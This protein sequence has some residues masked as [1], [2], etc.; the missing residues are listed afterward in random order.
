[1]LWEEYK[2]GIGPGLGKWFALSIMSSVNLISFFIIAYMPV[3]SSTTFY[4]VGYVICITDY[5][6]PRHGTSF[7]EELCR[8]HHWWMYPVFI[9]T[10][11][12]VPKAWVCSGCNSSYNL[13]IFLIIYPLAF[14][15]RWCVWLDNSFA[16]LL[17]L[18]IF[19]MLIIVRYT[20]N[21]NHN[22]PTVTE[23]SL[24]STFQRP[25]HAF[26]LFK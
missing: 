16:L 9:Q 3:L 20:N 1:M 23:C 2:C 26:S 18:Y 14:N 5:Q 6:T 25:R 24:C 4:S 10:S 19:V 7:S 11:Y 12:Q 22:L 8:V 17:S 21:R 15:F 13:Y